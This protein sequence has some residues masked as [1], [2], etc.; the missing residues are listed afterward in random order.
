MGFGLRAAGC[1]KTAIGIAVIVAIAAGR[2]Y[3]D[4]PGEAAFRA[5]EQQAAHGDASGAASAFEQIG[6]QYPA[7][8]WADDAWLEAGRQAE[9][10]GDYAR[11][12]R[13]LEHA[14]QAAG[15][16]LLEHRA[17]GELMRI[18]AITGAN[19][20]WAQVA[21]AHDQL[22]AELG[23]AGDPKP[24]LGKLEALVAANPGYPRAW[25][26]MIAIA[27]GWERDG[28]GDRA[29]AWLT[30]AQAAA[31]AGPD[32][33]HAT[34]ERVRALILYGELGEARA[35]IDAL[36]DPVVSGELRAQLHHAELRRDARWAVIALLLA[37]ALA[38]AIALRRAAGSWKAAARRLAHPPAEALYFVPVAIVLVAV[39]STGN[40]LAAAAVR[41]IAI[42]GAVI[43]WVSGAILDEL[44]AR[45]G[46]IGLRRAAGQAALAVLAVA[47][48]AFLA[49]EHGR[50]IDM[51]IETWREGPAIR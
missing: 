45:R 8:A 46:R 39:A 40:P 48:A 17:R 44:R 30:R 2:A 24:A 50:V 19:G 34:A 22:E 31:P 6:T 28:D 4:D 51:V 21:A 3:A 9:R 27:R 16:E 23:R 26:A 1:G 47:G 38:A 5:A 35:Q 13:D 14:V 10:A 29:L 32:R 20:Q 37:I 7:S 12:R 42:A 15:D 18:A 25:S 36:D 33:T 49:I 41:A 11:A 43:A